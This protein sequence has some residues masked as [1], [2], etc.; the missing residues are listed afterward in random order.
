MSLSS[1]RWPLARQP[2][3]RGFRRRADKLRFIAWA[4]LLGC[5]AV[6]LFL[7]LGTAAS[8][9]SAVMVWGVLLLVVCSVRAAQ[10]DSDGPK[11]RRQTRGVVP[12]KTR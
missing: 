12:D 2:D 3:T 11:Q 7:D 10:M 5:V 1:D 6:G 4:N 9:L 8:R